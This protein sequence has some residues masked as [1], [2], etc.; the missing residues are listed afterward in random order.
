MGLGRQEGWLAGW[1]TKPLI[2]GMS[3]VW[4]NWMMRR[5][6]SV[7]VIEYESVLSSL[8]LAQEM[9]TVVPDADRA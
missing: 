1:M 5:N 7:R 6:Y 4:V 8:S 9:Q 2:T 3:G